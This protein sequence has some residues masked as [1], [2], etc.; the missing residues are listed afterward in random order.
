MSDWANHKNGNGTGRAYV[1]SGTDGSLITALTG[2]APGDDFGIGVAE[3]GDVDRVILSEAKDDTALP[4]SS[5][6]GHWS[7]ALRVA[8]GGEDFII[9]RPRASGELCQQPVSCGRTLCVRPLTPS[10]TRR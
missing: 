10:E 9:L 4:R 6:L 5:S 2:E 3:A 8:Y 7:N 1:Y